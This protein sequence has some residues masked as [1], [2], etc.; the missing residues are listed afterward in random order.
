MYVDE[1]PGQPHRRHNPLEPPS[2]VM[3]LAATVGLA[4]V[5]MI[6]MVVGMAG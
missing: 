1:F 2:I 4:A 3:I 5:A 6:V